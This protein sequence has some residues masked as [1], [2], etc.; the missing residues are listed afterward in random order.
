MGLGK[1]L[2]QQLSQCYSTATLL[3]FSRTRVNDPLP[4]GHGR[5]QV[6]LG[7]EDDRA[8]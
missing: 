7:L 6:L 4:W 1:R 5:R 3:E 8:G 2:G